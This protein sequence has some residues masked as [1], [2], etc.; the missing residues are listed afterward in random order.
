M[1]KRR[2]DRLETLHRALTALGQLA[3]LITAI[4]GA[5][6]AGHNIGWW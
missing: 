2:P 4:T 6:I 5:A 3:P 1:P